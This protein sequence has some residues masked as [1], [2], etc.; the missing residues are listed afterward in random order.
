MSVDVGPGTRLLCV[1]A[2]QNP[3]MAQTHVGTVYTC[4]EVWSHDDCFQNNCHE[5]CAAGGVRL[6]EF[7]PQWAVVRDGL[8]LYRAEAL[9][10]LACFVPLGG[11]LPEEI[12][13][14]L[15]PTPSYVKYFKKQDARRQ[16][17][18]ITEPDNIK[19][20]T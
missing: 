2:N 6:A 19:E 12:L 4:A 10:C 16:L 18:E 20:P 11:S 15:N 8:G 3:R 7:G 17:E 13:A 9:Y 5:G 1:E 14:T